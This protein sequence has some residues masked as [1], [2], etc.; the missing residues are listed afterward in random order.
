MRSRIRVLLAAGM[1]LA[2]CGSGDETTESSVTSES[3]TSVASSVPSESSSTVPSETSSPVPTA[4]ADDSQTASTPSAS[5]VP[6]TPTPPEASSQLE[7]RVPDHIR[8][9][10]DGLVL[11]VGDVETRV[12][13]GPVEWV[14]SDGAGGFVYPVDDQ[15]RWWPAASDNATP[16]EAKGLFARLV[17]G[18]PTLIART[19]ER[20][21]DDGEF[22]WLVLHDLASGADRHLACVGWG[23][24]ATVGAADFGGDRYVV[25]WGMDLANYST[26]HGLIIG[27][28]GA[29]DSAGPLWSGL[30]SPGNPYPDAET[31]RVQREGEPMAACE[32]HGRLSPDG[33]LLATWYRPDLSFVVDPMEIPPEVV[34]DEAGW[35]ARLD[36]LPAELTVHELDTGI[37]RYRTKLSARSRI[38]D[39]DGRFVV[40]A[41]LCRVYTND[42]TCPVQDN[43]WAV[44]DTGGE[45]P[46]VTVQGAA[47]LLRPQGDSASI[48]EVDA[49]TLRR[50]DTGAWVSFLQQG[51][52][53]RGL[54]ID[55]DGI[56]GPV[57]ES[58]VRDLQLDAGLV[59]DGIVGPETWTAVPGDSTITASEKA[60]AILRP[61]GLGPIDFGTRV[62]EALTELSG[63]LRSPNVDEVIGPL[64]PGTEDCVEGA[65]WEHCLRANGV[66]H[67]GRIVRWTDRGLSIAFT[68]AEGSA[69]A[70]TPTPLQFSS[71]R[72]V[73]PAGGNVLT[74][75][76]GIGP[77]ST[78]GELRAAYPEHRW[79]F[80]EG[81]WDGVMFAIL[82]GEDCGGCVERGI[83][84]QL[85]YSIVPERNGYVEAIQQALN[86]QGASLAV[87][88]EIGPRTQAAWEQFC[89]AH[90]LSCTAEWPNFPWFITDEQ[91][92]ALE[93]PPPD[94]TI[95]ALVS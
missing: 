8:Y 1:L 19:D 37:E 47:A 25:E 91:R 3:S 30:D 15:V 33:T 93:F 59:V 71:W 58:A 81:A 67:E 10:S 48:T 49:P 51:L 29:T 52:V 13:D 40:V 46:P 74:T 11:V 70:L 14:S 62:E 22:F 50:G 87:D 56:F 27:E 90:D 43:P 76:E 17:D 53:A 18:R 66:L 38:A 61:Y 7:V 94:V 44:I 95:A 45:Q 5:S 9:G 84:G 75:S 92:A 32:V 42:A 57:T 80:N 16:I 26:K 85:D 28:L 63:I 41:P 55:V 2:G 73:R 86:A 89:A 88:G 82:R 79:L 77:G 23:G 72:A 39:F 12:I 24:D 64:G 83:W 21:S 6:T 69:G 78:V 54:T 65:S 36:T 31:C 68:D 20:C 60:T 35:L 34:A 4:T